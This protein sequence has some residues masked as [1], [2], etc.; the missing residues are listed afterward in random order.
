MLAITVPRGQFWDEKNNKFIYSDETVLKLEHSLIAISKWESRYHKSYLMTANKTESESRYYIKCMTINNVSDD[1][2]YWALTAENIDAIDKYI[3]N[4][5]SAVSFDGKNKD[6]K[7]NKDNKHKKD[8]KREGYMNTSEFIYYL[9]AS[10]NI[11][12]EYEKWHIERLLN[13]LRICREEAEKQNEDANSKKKEQPRTTA[14]QLD[15]MAALNERNKAA[16][17][18]RG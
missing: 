5:M 6:K 9:M 18:T 12:H 13:L 7:S 3:H 8:N 4:P 17:H 16:L 2:V 11:P 1:K 15:R 14:Q 10:Y